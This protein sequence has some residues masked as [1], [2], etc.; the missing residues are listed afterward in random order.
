MDNDR[1]LIIRIIPEV[2]IHAWFDKIA[3]D[4]QKGFFYIDDKE[5]VDNIKKVEA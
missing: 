1:D 4:G 5:I 3:E 2:K